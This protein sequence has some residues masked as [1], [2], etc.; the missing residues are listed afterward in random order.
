MSFVF[1]LE[2]GLVRVLINAL[3][4]LGPVRA[5]NLGGALLRWVGPLL[6]VARVADTNLRIAFPDMDAATRR[7]VARGAFESLGRTVAEMPHIAALRETASGPGWEITGRAVIDRLAESGGPAI[8]FSGHLGNWE[9]LPRASAS[10]GVV[11]SGMYR[12]AANPLIDAMMLAMRRE[13]GGP[14]LQMFPK[15]AAGARGALTHLRAG[16]VLAMLMDQKM[17]DGIEATLFGQKAMTAPALAALALRFGCPVI[18]AYAE[19]I[20]PA[21]FRLVCEAPL[22]LP[23]TGDRQADIRAITQA[24]NNVL[25]RWVRAMPT[26]WL[27]MHRRFP[28]PVYR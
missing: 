1:R 9:V 24:V 14:T 17:N 18:P 8:F 16:G 28:K 6:P 23:N 20:G 2:A 27:W 4:A 26:S 7:R 15:G 19:R 21:R 5:S 12:A 25:E 11:L 13:A 3:C 22:V 10:Y